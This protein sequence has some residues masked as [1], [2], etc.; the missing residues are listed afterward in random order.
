[1]PEKLVVK[2]DS[3]HAGCLYTRRSTTGIAV[4]LGGHTL[5][6]STHFQSTIGLSSGESEYYDIVKASQQGL[7]TQALLADWRVH[8]LVQV[9][10][11]S[12]AA[13]GIAGRIGLGSQRHV[14]TRYLWVQE[15]VSRNSD[16]N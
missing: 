3:D 2:G 7:G 6:N 13:L 12:N 15:K 14:N 10:S 16:Q 4:R 8:V 9:D 1:M 5:K 11:D